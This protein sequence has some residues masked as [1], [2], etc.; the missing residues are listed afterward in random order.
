MD[1]IMMDNNV[2][3]HFS[4][5][6]YTTPRVKPNVKYRLWVVMMCQYR[7]VSYKKYSLLMGDVSNGEKL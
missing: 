4:N 5:T 7:F 2:I 6:E 1:V 3:V